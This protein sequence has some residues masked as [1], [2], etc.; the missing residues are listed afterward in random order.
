ME[1]SEF[2]KLK[3]TLDSQV[4]K[5]VGLKIVQ[6]NNSIA[7]A[8][9]QNTQIQT[10]KDL[11]QL[12]REN[13]VAFALYDSFYPSPSDPGAYIDYSHEKGDNTHTWSMT[14]GNHGWTGGIY[15]IEE[16][17]IANQI[18]NLIK[19]KQIDS[20]RIDNV[21]IDAHYCKKTGELNEKQN[22][23]LSKIHTTSAT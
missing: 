14:L 3:Q 16:G 12:L 13:K 20:I 4:N 5:I 18:Y 2:L 23:L 11:L 10:V 6:K 9:E 15:S 17:V 21:K 1:I 7:I 8:I 22:D 19:Q